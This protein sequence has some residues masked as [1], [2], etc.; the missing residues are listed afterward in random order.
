MGTRGWGTLRRMEVRGSM[1]NWLGRMPW[2]FGWF[3]FLGT[4]F[5]APPSADQICRWIRQLEARDFAVRAE[6]S[7]KLGDAGDAALAPLLTSTAK[8]DAETAWLAAGVLEQIALH[9]NESTL[10]R[11]T[12]GLEALSRGGNPG[13]DG[14]VGQL[15]TRQARL[16]RERAVRTIR[17]L[18]GRFEGDEKAPV[19]PATKVF[20]A[21]RDNDRALEPPPEISAGQ[22]TSTVEPTESAGIGFVGD[23]YISP[24][25][26]NGA[27]N[28]E[29]ELVL[30]I[31]EQWRGGD[32]GL[33]AL[34][35]LG[36]RVRLRFQHAPLTDAALKQIAAIPHL[37]SVEVE[38]CHFSAE[39][40]NALR[41]CQPRMQ[42]VIDGK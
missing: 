30:T 32:A 42:I 1:Y 28:K 8:A 13:I 18:G 41:Q 35:D 20:A 17:S 39:A 40:L 15:Q 16:Q 34:L 25:F 3:F 21:S 5:G 9:G 11:V 38:G 22:P 10:R 19:T 6:A 37:Q 27:E 36:S 14:I 26:F 33:A 23:A 31:G 2:A 7:Q 29:A 4:A 12:E 24:E